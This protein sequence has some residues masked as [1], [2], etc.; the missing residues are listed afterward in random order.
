MRFEDE[1]SGS[2]K[3]GV[4]GRGAFGGALFAGFSEGVIFSA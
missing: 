4:C 3:S 1:D 2:E